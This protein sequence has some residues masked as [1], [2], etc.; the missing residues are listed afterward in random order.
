MGSSGG[1]STFTQPDIP[2][3]SGQMTQTPGGA[4]PSYPQFLTGLGGAGSMATGLTP[5]MIA[6]IE[7]SAAAAAPPVQQASAV[8]VVQPRHQLAQ[9]MQQS[10][11]D[12]QRRGGGAER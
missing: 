2:A 10:Q 7:G 12:R 8:P 4:P 9:V 5:E 11:A 3:P 6:A 1:S